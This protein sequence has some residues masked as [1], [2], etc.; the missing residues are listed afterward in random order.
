ML[1]GEFKLNM[2]YK[3]GYS[4]ILVGQCIEFPFVIVQGNTPDDLFKEISHEIEVY[5]NTFPEEWKHFIEQHKENSIIEKEQ[6]KETEG[7]MEKKI[8]IPIR[9]R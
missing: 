3:K 9:I 1:E 6:I 7:W 5:F 8:E 4:G 2:R